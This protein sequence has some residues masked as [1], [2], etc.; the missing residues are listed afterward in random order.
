MPT[1]KNKNMSEQFIN[2]IDAMCFRAAESDLT[3]GMADMSHGEFAS[4]SAVLT[5][6]RC[7]YARTLPATFNISVCVCEPKVSNLTQRQITDPCYWT[8]R[9]PYLYDCEIELKLAAG[10]ALSAKRTVGFRRW[11]TDGRHFLLER[12]RTVLRG[13][14]A[15][16]ENFDLT[17]AHDAEVTV[18]ID[19]PTEEFLQQASEVGVMVVADIRGSTGDLI[20]RLLSFSWQPS[21]G[22]VL[23]KMDACYVPNSQL[24]A[25]SLG[26]DKNTLA[27]QCR[28]DWVKA[29]FVEL[30]ATERPPGELANLDMPVIAI[31]RGVN[32][33][34][35]HEA[36]AACD[37]LQAELAPEFDLAGYFVAP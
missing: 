16:Q 17:S 11:E 37:R 32:F 3:F 19:N 36:R 13:V 18:L 14:V 33:A 4:F 22:L 23:P 34:N 25:A 2:K 31:R 29:I 8:P 21:V 28:E 5:G 30:D 1:T 20:S 12:K 10:S 15:E 27:G 26:A 6:P 9:L 35:L 7:K 24:L